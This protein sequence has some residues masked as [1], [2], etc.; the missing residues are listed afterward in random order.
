LLETVKKY[1]RDEVG[2][3]S[4]VSTEIL[5]SKASDVLAIEQS[6]ELALS[7]A[8]IL[9]LLFLQLGWRDGLLATPPNVLPVAMILGMMG[10]AGITLNVGTSLIASAA[11]GIAVDDTMHLVTRVREARRHWEGDEISQLFETSVLS[12]HC[13]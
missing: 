13:V 12:W 11:L 5:L 2:P 6:K 10:V 3:R 1:F 9:G 7:A 8:L 4:I